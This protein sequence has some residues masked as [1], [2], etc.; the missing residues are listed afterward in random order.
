MTTNYCKNCGANLSP[1]S[2]FCENCGQPIDAAPTITQ[3]S[4]KAPQAPTPSLKPRPRRDAAFW[5]GTIGGIFGIFLGAG[6]L[7]IAVVFEL[8]LVSWL[9]FIGIIAFSII[10]GSVASTT[11]KRTTINAGLSILAGVGMLFLAFIFGGV[12]MSIADLF[13]ILSYIAGALMFSALLFFI[14][15]VLIY[16]KKG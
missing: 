3:E 10:G 9:P 7:V 8:P 14:S 11:A 2:K 6:L 4:Y 5:L 16:L 12:G 13:G 1:E 15:G